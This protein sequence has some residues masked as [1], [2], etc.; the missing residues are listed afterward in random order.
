MWN[1]ETAVYGA[2][3]VEINFAQD[4]F[5]AFVSRVVAWKGPSYSL[6]IVSEISH[7]VYA[8]SKV[9]LLLNPLHTESLKNQLFLLSRV[10]AWK[11]PS[12]SLVNTEVYLAVCSLQGYQMDFETGMITIPAENMSFRVIGSKKGSKEIEPN[13]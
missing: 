11:G 10:V 9:C 1:G 12:Y 3:E 6:V 7:L 4:C 5:H 8:K 2:S 13:L